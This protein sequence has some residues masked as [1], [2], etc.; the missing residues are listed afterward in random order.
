MSVV[1]LAWQRYQLRR[2][3]AAT[4]IK[5]AWKG[6]LARSAYRCTVKA[7]AEV[8]ARALRHQQKDAAVQI[9]VPQHI[10]F[11]KAGASICAA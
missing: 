3:Q 4:K 8:Q 5:A 2:A 11:G 7:V 6:H 1:Q 9:Q 10:C